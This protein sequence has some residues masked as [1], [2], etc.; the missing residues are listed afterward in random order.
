MK[1][2]GRCTNTKK[3]RR[4][5]GPPSTSTAPIHTKGLRAT[6]GTHETKVCSVTD[7]AR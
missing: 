2:R 5:T 6:D 3:V 7:L 1:K 4:F